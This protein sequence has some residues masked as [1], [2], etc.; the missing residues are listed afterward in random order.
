VSTLHDNDTHTSNVSNKE[1][2]Q[3]Y[4]RAERIHDQRVC[5]VDPDDILLPYMK[6]GLPI[7][8]S[9]SSDSSSDSDSDDDDDKTDIIAN[10]NKNQEIEFVLSE[11]DDDDHEDEDDFGNPIIYAGGSEDEEYLY[12]HLSASAYHQFW[13][14]GYRAALFDLPHQ[15]LFNF[16]CSVVAMY[17]L[18]RYFGCS[19]WEDW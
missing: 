8:S 7:G 17:A 11:C 18:K 4:D 15:L 6:A 1:Q 9:M 19:I 10:N 5:P 14:Y 16:C 13:G 2:Q 3:E 12:H